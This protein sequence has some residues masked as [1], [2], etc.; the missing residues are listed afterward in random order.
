MSHILEEHKSY[1]VAV[2][3]SGP[4]PESLSLWLSVLDTRGFKKTGPSYVR[5][6]SFEKPPQETGA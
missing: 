1:T 4:S 2:A 3:L 6:A 5:I